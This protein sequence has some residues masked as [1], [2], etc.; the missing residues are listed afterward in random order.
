MLTKIAKFFRPRQMQR[1]EDILEQENTF[2]NVNNVL[3]ASFPDR[4][5]LSRL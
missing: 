3:I 1:K 2:F 5:T 4:M